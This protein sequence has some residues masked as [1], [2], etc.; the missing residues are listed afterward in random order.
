[1]T[2][3]LSDG[4]EALARAGHH[5]LGA[6]VEGTVRGPLGAMFITLGGPEQESHEQAIADLRSALGPERYGQLAAR[7]ASMTYEEIV[8]YALAELDRLI[9]ESASSTDGASGMG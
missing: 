8:E 1:V 9:A 3:V 4:V 5:E 6:L 7:G 2:G